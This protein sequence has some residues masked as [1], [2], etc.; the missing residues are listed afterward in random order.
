[1]P[2][3]RG[4][5]TVIAWAALTACGTAQDTENSGSQYGILPEGVTPSMISEGEE[6]FLGV[7]GCHICH[8][9]DAS[10]ARGVGANLTDQEWWHTDGSWRG[11]AERIRVGV[12]ADSVRNELGA[13]MPARGGS[14]ITDA[15]TNAVAAYVWSLR[16]ENRPAG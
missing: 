5:P 4:I 11:I 1:M 12:P 9:E 14:S 3:V 15:Q 13:M 2:R 8:G 10:G 6:I 7:G 16:V